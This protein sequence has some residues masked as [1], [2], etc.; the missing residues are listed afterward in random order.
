MGGFPTGVGFKLSAKLALAVPFSNPSA[1]F[2]ADSASIAF[3]PSGTR[4]VCVSGI[5]AH[6][7][8]RECV[9]T[10]GKIYPDVY[11]ELR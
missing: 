6:I 11:V 3:I 5:C 10:T 4:E 9:T 1:L 8:C 2:I 7:A